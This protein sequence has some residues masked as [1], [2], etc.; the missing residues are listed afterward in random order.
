VRHEREDAV[1]SPHPLITAE[2]LETSI[3]NSDLRVVDCRFELLRPLAGRSNYLQG[4]I[5]GAVFADLDRDLAAPTGPATGRHPLPEP[6]ELAGTFGRFGIGAETHV[7][8][9]DDCN[10]ALAAR[11]WWLLRWLGHERVFLLEGG[12]KRWQ[13]LQLPL[14]AGTVQ[15]PTRAFDPAP[16]NDLILQTQEIVA[17][18]R[19]GKQLRLVDARDAARFRGEVEPIDAVAGHVPGAINLPFGECLNEDGTWKEKEDLI[20]TWRKVL[21]DDRDAPWNVM[22]GSGVTACHLVISGQL[23][24][25]REPRLYVGSWSEWIADPQRAIATGAA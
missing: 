16:R 5:P 12:I 21:G 13:R 9:Y 11:A 24:G 3:G 6:A 10:G 7:V 19:Q 18:G 4:H 8:V 23:A 17:A 1:T 14:E 15:V 20:R 22:C 2:E 25:R